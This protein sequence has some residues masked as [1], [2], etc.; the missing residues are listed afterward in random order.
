MIEK[1]VT[2]MSSDDFIDKCKHLVFGYKRTRIK[3]VDL[4]SRFKPDDVHV[5]WSFKVLKNNKA[6][7]ITNIPD[8]MYY[9]ITYNGA[10]DEFY[11]DVYKKFENIKYDA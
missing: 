6:L 3:D 1:K 7:L 5:V 4:L 8:G 10:S 11:M 2:K 9:E